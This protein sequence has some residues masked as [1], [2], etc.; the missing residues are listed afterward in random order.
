MIITVAAQ[1]GGVSKT[2]TAAAIAQGLTWKKKRTL[3]I[4]ADSQ[5]SATLIYG[6]DDSGGGLYDLITG[7][8]QA[9][10][11]IQETPAGAIIPGSD[12][13]DRLD[14]E[15]NNQPGRDSLLK[16][17]IAPIVPDFQ[18]VIIDTAPGLGT[19][20]I[21]ALTAADSVI[22]PLLCDPQALAGLHQI[23]ETINQVKKYCNPS[24]QIAAVLLTQYQ[25]R[26]MLTRQYEELI[27]EQC[28]EMGLYLAETRIRK[29]IA[30]QEA[31]ASRENL[32]SYAPKSNPAADY[33]AFINEL[34]LTRKGRRKNG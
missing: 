28:R 27:T 32:Y 1:K 20:L 6:A 11:L 2:S 19:C 13:L 16:A 25:G 17:G 33:M 15:L 26:A 21:Q 4:D 9:A 34:N 14:V 7:K 22:I 12:L 10:E 23:T 18:H 29:G 31:Q 3:L 5:R 8:A 30:L 24:L